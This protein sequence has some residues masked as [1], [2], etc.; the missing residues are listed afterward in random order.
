MDVIKK[1]DRFS[2]VHKILHIDIHMYYVYYVHYVYVYIYIYVCLQNWHS[3]CLAAKSDE[4]QY[5]LDS[6]AKHIFQKGQQT[7][8]TKKVSQHRTRV[9]LAQRS[10]FD[11]HL[12]HGP[13]KCHLKTDGMSLTNPHVIVKI[14]KEIKAVIQNCCLSFSSY[15]RSHMALSFFLKLPSSILPAVSLNLSFLNRSVINQLSERKLRLR[16]PWN[17]I[18]KCEQKSM[19]LQKK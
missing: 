19:P 6:T 1:Q 5:I 3:D 14:L 15:C 8:K 7:L 13:V 4:K 11:R 12:A 17:G 10:D 18:K 2:D 16:P 9:R